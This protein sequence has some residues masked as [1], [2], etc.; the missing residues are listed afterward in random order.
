MELRRRPRTAMTVKWID[1]LDEVVWSQSW[2]RAC[3]LRV[4][5]CLWFKGREAGVGTVRD[6]RRCCFA[7]RCVTSWGMCRVEDGV[8]WMESA[9]VDLHH[10]R[11]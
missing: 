4:S 1:V 6:L 10:A 7:T 5:L 3:R 11:W 8:E 2:S 9:V